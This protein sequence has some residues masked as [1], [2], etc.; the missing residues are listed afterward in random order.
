MP[1]ARVAIS[2]NSDLLARVDALATA[3]GQSRSEFVRK[4]LEQVLS[5]QE[6]ERAVAEARAIYLDVEADSS[7][8]AMHEAFL[9]AAQDTAPAY[10]AAVSGDSETA[11][12][13]LP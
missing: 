13:R 9:A 8:Q 5:V 12:K 1:V 4:S 11:A 3:A 6:E 7:Q 2:L 10:A